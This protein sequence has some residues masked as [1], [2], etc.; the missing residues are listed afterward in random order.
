MNVTDLRNKLRTSA[1]LGT[2]MQIP[3]SIVC[4][5]LSR[6][7]FD[8]LALDLEHGR[9]DNN[10]I[11]DFFNIIKSNNCLPFARLLS[12]YSPNEISSVLDAGA[13]G[14]IFPKLE[15][16]EQARLIYSASNLPP[17]GTRG[18]AFCHA[19][20]YGSDFDLY[21]EKGQSTFLVGM[22]ESQLGV[23][24][25]PHI[26]S[27]NIFDAFVVGPYDLSASLGLTGMFDSPRFLSV[28]DS[29]YDTL[30]A[31]SIPFGSHVVYP[32]TDQLTSSLRRGCRFIPHGID[33]TFFPAYF[34]KLHPMS[35]LL[36]PLCKS[37]HT[38]INVVTPHVFGSNISEGPF[39]HVIIVMLFFT[40]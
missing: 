12:T 27:E 19:N 2:W 35:L 40:P 13:A 1:S 23:D 36:C 8:W 10:V 21:L 7:D 16:V 33:T 9:F 15:T 11:G 22:I 14:L 3:S 20:N 37:D 31:S 24:N 25:L 26:L 4:N 5:L 28:L 29:I 6:H 39:T 38:Y 30:N 18:V 32:S 17:T 34:L